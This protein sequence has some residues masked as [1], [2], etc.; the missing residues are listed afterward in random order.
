MTVAILP[1]EVLLLHE[2]ETLIQFV[3]PEGC[4]EALDVIM[5]KVGGL[6]LILPS[7]Q[8]S[9]VVLLYTSVDSTQDNGLASVISILEVSCYPASETFVTSYRARTP[10]EH[11][12]SEYMTDPRTSSSELINSFLFPPDLGV[13]ASRPQSSCRTSPL[14]LQ[15]R[16][17]Y[18]HA[19]Y[20]KP[21]FLYANFICTSQRWRAL[22][23]PN[24][25]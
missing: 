21:Y 17:I 11:Y 15:G 5:P 24:R 4:G 1:Q 14:P 10:R 20:E 12:L 7:V 16:K 2:I 23:E 8:A 22:L 3:P 19:G 6:H 18:Q 9:P 25:H 13:L